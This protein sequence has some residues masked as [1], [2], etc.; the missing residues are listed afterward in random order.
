[1]KPGELSSVKLAAKR[2]RIRIRAVD[3][4]IVERCTGFGVID[5][6]K[7]KTTHAVDTTANPTVRLDLGTKDGMESM[8]IGFTDERL[9][10]G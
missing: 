5:G 3:G 1:M 7:Q 9:T 4:V 6:S 10:G 2:T 8:R